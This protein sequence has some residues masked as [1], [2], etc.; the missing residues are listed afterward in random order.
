MAGRLLIL[1]VRE[2][3]TCPGG[4]GREGNHAAGL[5]RGPLV[6]SS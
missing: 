2:G 5:G 3:D 6:G 4:L 1:R